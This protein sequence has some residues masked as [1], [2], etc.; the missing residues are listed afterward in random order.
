M[1]AYVRSK[2]CSSVLWVDSSDV[3]M[4]DGEG[5]SAQK[6]GKDISGKPEWKSPRLLWRGTQNRKGERLKQH[7]AWASFS[8]T[9]FFWVP[10]QDGVRKVL[11][12]AGAP[13]K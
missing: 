1:A 11:Q 6:K 7:K 8:G 12:A 13:A 5:V 4:G 3:S 10:M 2:P 9:A